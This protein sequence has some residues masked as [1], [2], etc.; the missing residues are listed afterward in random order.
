[1]GGRGLVGKGPR[2]AQNPTHIFSE[3]GLLLLGVL[4]LLGLLH[5][6]ALDESR[7]LRP[8]K[9]GVEG[10]DAMRCPSLPKAAGSPE[11]SGEGRGGRLALPEGPGS[12]PFPH[13]LLTRVL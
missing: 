5:L 9:V 7:C 11:G 3:E 4:G 12:V 2:G 6:Q 8:G 10:G 1:M 13:P